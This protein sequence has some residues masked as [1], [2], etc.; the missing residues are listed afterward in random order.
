[1]DKY[2]VSD[3]SDW[4]DTRLTEFAPLD[5]SLR[6][7]VCKDYY[8]TPMITSC[9]HTFCS[10]CIRRTLAADGKCP[11]CRSND[12][13]SKLRRNG[14]MELLVEMFQAARPV[15][16]KLAREQRYS[17]EIRPA[18]TT[19]ASKRKAAEAD[20]E[21]DGAQRSGQRR[22]TRSQSRKTASSGT[23]DMVISDNEKDKDYQPE[24]NLV[25]CPICNKRMKQEA[26]FPHL[27]HCEGEQEQDRR[28]GQRK[29][30][31]KVFYLDIWTCSWTN[32]LQN[33]KLC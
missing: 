26:V 4:L 21:D 12:Q 7:E 10:L 8:N 9:S 3:P 5:A 32:I 18:A 29:R 19:S 13:A 17:P 24:D 16:L 31:E 22:K 1:M 11:I 33:T 6:C 2:D 14:A 28:M 20:L 15:A 25:A 27:D 23:P 30:S